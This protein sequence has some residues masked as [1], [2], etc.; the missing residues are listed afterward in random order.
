MKFYEKNRQQAN[1]ILNNHRGKE[2]I[3][4]LTEFT[5]ETNNNQH[6]VN[7]KMQESSESTE[8]EYMRII[9]GMR[10]KP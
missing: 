2:I 6:I 7:L 1:Q 9:T 3:P 4:M 5:S 10:V 8:E